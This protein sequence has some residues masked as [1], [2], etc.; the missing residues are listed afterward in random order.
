MSISLRARLFGLWLM[1]LF[2][3]L[4][5]AVLI[6]GLFRQTA[7]AHRERDRA[8]AARACQAITAHYDFYTANM[9]A[10]PEAATFR[11]G[12][13]VVLQVA[14]RRQRGIVAAIEPSD[15]SATP[16]V[17]AMYGTIPATLSAVVAD[18]INDA[19]A[20]DRLIVTTKGGFLN[21]TTIAT[22]PLGGPLGTPVANIAAV[23]VLQADLLRSAFTRF[24][25]GGL[26]VLLG[27]MLASAGFLAWLV[28][29]FSRRLAG[30]ETALASDHPGLL[31][32]T[33]EA[34]LDR[35]IT[36][37][38][39]ATTRL[40]AARARIAQSERL[41][42]L[43]RM[44]AGLAHEIRNPLGAIRLRA[45]TGLAAA[46]PARRAAA[47]DRILVEAA[48]LEALTTSLL[49]FAATPSPQPRATDLD[50][51]ITAAIGGP[52]AVSMTADPTGIIWPLDPILTRSAL[53]NLLRNAI[54]AC[55]PTDSITITAQATQN[56]TITIA[57]TGPGIDPALG[58]PFEPFTTGRADGI[59]L[60][61]AIARDMI[62]A[63]GG[64]L[65]RAPAT[66]GAAF[67]I[68]L[69]EG[70]GET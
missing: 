14:L 66:V 63:Q 10:E 3:S 34:E 6:I 32:L 17:A 8:V 47:L 56:L 37:L 61:L 21:R 12:L 35:L 1:S 36:A 52:V 69:P 31:D 70:T 54:A 15:P 24:A 20:A 59:G 43:G 67:V 30:V 64:T 46:D 51:L 27:T 42:A 60:G 2:G 38:N 33:G 16:G 58:D 40:D 11:A 44:A 48:R 26:A 9:D 45:E 4:V 23:T 53:E 28:L 29:G 55:A 22:C 57:D 7:A 19:I 49:G 18:Q 68:T 13:R 25:F 5:V 39:A 41:A 50:A 62:R 65:V